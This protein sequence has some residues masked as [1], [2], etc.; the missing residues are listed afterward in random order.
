[1]NAGILF[2]KVMSGLNRYNLR[3][4][5]HNSMDTSHSKDTLSWI[6]LTLD[7]EFSS[8]LFKVP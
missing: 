4:L 1:M 6:D 2:L 7:T 8:S 3:I 5:I